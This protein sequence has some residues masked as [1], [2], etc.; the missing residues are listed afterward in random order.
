MIR[1]YGVEGIPQEL[2]FICFFEHASHASKDSWT[3]RPTIT[4]EAVTDEE[5]DEGEDPVSEGLSQ[6][7]GARIAKIL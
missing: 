1:K 7:G 6:G 3:P 2:P 5:E 4:G